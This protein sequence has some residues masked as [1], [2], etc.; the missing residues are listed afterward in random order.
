[1]GWNKQGFAKSFEYCKLVL[2]KKILCDKTTWLAY[3]C[4]LTPQQNWTIRNIGTCDLHGTHGGYFGRISALKNHVLVLGSTLIYCKSVVLSD[5]GEGKRNGFCVCILF[6]P[7]VTTHAHTSTESQKT[8]LLPFL[9]SH[10]HTQV[11]K[12][13]R[14]S[15][16]HSCI[17][18]LPVSRCCF[19]YWIHS[20]EHV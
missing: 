8:I 18:Y 9:Y 17:E 10:K 20:L 11:Q 2:S 7:R 14:P 3:T 5:V 13:T 1:M 4:Y 19:F 12:A 6:L 15:C 16:Y